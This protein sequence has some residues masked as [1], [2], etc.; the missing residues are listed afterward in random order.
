MY[1]FAPC[2]LLLPTETK[3]GMG[4]PGTGVTDNC[5]LPCVLGVE[6]WSSSREASVHSH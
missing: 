6:L 3:E 5:K 1:A 4:L 2:T